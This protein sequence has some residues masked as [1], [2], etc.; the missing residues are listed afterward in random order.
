MGHVDAH[1]SE[2]KTAYHCELEKIL[3][4]INHKEKKF[5]DGFDLYLPDLISKKKEDL[6]TL[7][8][9]R[10]LCAIELKHLQRLARA[11]SKRTRTAKTVSISRSFY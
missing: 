10:G 6:T 8:M 5:V 7:T 9:N 11:K 1:S 2:D 4:H 3:S